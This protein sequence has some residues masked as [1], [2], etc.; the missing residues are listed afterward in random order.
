LLLPLIAAGVLGAGSQG[1]PSPAAIVLEVRGAI[2]PAAADYVLRGLGEAE[3]QN[4]PLA[5]I[6]MDTPGGLDS[7]MRDIIRGILASSVP[8]ATYVTPPGARAASAGTYILYA[9]H[10]AAMAPGT[11]APCT[12]GRHDRHRSG[13][14]GHALHAGSCPSADRAGLANPLLGTITDPNVALIL[15]MIGFYGLIFEFMNPG[16]IVPGT[17]GAISLLLGL[18]A[19]AVLPIDYA[20]LGLIL[21]GL[22]L[23]IAEAFAP[24]FGILG[25]GGV[26]AFGLG[27]T[28]LIDTDLPA[29]AISLPL[30]DALSLVSLGF[31]VL[32]LRMALRNRRFA[33]AASKVVRLAPTQRSGRRHQ[34]DPRSSQRVQHADTAEIDGDH[35]KAVDAEPEDCPVVPLDQAC[36]INQRDE[37]GPRDGRPQAHF[38]PNGALK[39]PRAAAK[40]IK[41]PVGRPDEPIWTLRSCRL[42]F[43]PVPKRFD[44]AKT[45]S[46]RSRPGAPAESPG[47]LAPLLSMSAGVTVSP[48]RVTC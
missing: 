8:V 33:V 25:I 11:R 29:F 38:K 42:P 43:A 22:G 9:S 46:G 34:K 30:I 20:G 24:S 23:M 37:S 18:Y 1:Q 12:R 44:T 40:V 16:A 17:I 35:R 5:I 21:L 27:A 6:E 26:I 41:Q 45:Q 47:K 13:R 32:V 48:P 19:F 3:E 39:A 28:I 36:G 14:G 7:S 10:V 15:M 31:M 4:A 2:G